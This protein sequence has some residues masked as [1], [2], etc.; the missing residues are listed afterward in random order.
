MNIGSVPGFDVLQGTPARTAIPGEAVLSAPV[1]TASTPAP[2]AAAPVTTPATP[3]PANPYQDSYN[4]IV[5]ASSVALMQSLGP[6]ASSG[7]EY[8]PGSAAEG[9]S[10][11]STMLSALKAG[12]AQG[13]FSGTGFDRL[14]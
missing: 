8:A 1:K 3:A 2:I 11:I 7:P 14:V 5:T 6:V 12:L 9:F 10:E 4:Q 13:M